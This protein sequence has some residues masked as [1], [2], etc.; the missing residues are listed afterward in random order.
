[1][2]SQHGEEPPR[3]HLQQGNNVTNVVVAHSSKL[4]L[5][6]TLGDTSW[7]DWMIHG[8]LKNA[9]KKDTTPKYVI[10]VDTGRT[11]S[12]L[13]I[14]APYNQLCSPHRQHHVVIIGIDNTSPL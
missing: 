9:F 7:Q 6:F 3:Q 13:S 5:E 4:E 10:I 14:G 1:V 11:Q 12:R 2:D 8:H